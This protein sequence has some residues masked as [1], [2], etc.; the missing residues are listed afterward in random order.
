MKRLVLYILCIW[1]IGAAIE[2]NDLNIAVIW[3]SSTD[4]RLAPRGWKVGTDVTNSG[5]DTTIGACPAPEIGKAQLKI[6]LSSFERSVPFDSTLDTTGIPDVLRNDGGI[7]DGPYKGKFKKVR[8][9]DRSSMPLTLDDIK[10]DFK[11]VKPDA[12]IYI[13]AGAEWVKPGGDDG[14]LYELLRAAADN[15]IGIMTIGDASLI[16]AR[17]IDPSKERFPVMGVQKKYRFKAY[18][19]DAT[20]DN[21][22]IREFNFVTTN[23]TPEWEIPDTVVLHSDYDASKNNAN[24]A[25]YWITLG[26]DTIYYKTA[27]ETPKINETILKEEDILHAYGEW[28]INAKAVEVVDED[29]YAPEMAA[30][31]Y[32]NHDM[33]LT[34]SGS[35]SNVTPS[36][37][38]KP[39][40]EIM[41]VNGDKH[42]S[43]NEA[44]P[45][46]AS[47]GTSSGGVFRFDKDYV[48]SKS[49]IDDNT[50]TDNI[51]VIKKGDTIKASAD[52]KD[53]LY[54]NT[55]YAGGYKNL[56]IR[57]FDD[58]ATENIF[59]DV[60][61]KLKAAGIKDLKFKPWT[62]G[63][64]IKAA[65]DIWAVNEKLTL[66]DF[67]DIDS[68]GFDPDAYYRAYLGDQV[69]GTKGNPHFV[70][71]PE[72]GGTWDNGDFDKDAKDM[73]LDSLGYD[74]DGKLYH[75][76]SA[77]QNGHRR[78]VMLGFQPSYLDDLDAVLDLLEDATKWI[79]ID[80]YQLPT[81]E[82][83]PIEDGKELKPADGQKIYTDQDSIKLV[84]DFTKKGIVLHEAAFK[85]TYEI[86]YGSEV[87]NGS[88]TFEADDGSEHIEDTIID[89]TSLISIDRD[90]TAD[91]ELKISVF[92]EPVVDNAPFD[93]SNTASARLKIRKLDAKFKSGGNNESIEFEGTYNEEIISDKS[94]YGDDVSDVKI[95]F[96]KD[97]G[98]WQEEDATYKFST[99][100]PTLSIVATAKKDRY[101]NSDTLQREYEK[102]DLMLPK[103]TVDTKAADVNGTGKYFFFANTSLFMGLEKYEMTGGIAIT[104]DDY[105]L[106]FKQSSA[107]KTMPDTGLID[108]PLQYI[109]S[110]I[111]EGH[112]AFVIEDAI[113]VAE[114]QS[115]LENSN[116]MDKQS[117]EFR[118]VDLSI[119]R[120][121]GS[122][123]D[124][125][126]KVTFK[127]TDP[128]TNEE[129]SSAKI[130]YSIDGSNAT[131]SS[132]GPIN[133]SDEVEII[134]G[135]T[136]KA[137]AVRSGY[138]DGKETKS[139]AKDVYIIAD[140]ESGTFFGESLD[141][142]LTSNHQPIH[143]TIDG[144]SEL[145]IDATEGDIT[146]D[147]ALS[148]L[149]R[150]NDTVVIKAWIED[151]DNIEGVTETFSYYR[152]K[153][154][155]PKVDPASGKY[156]GSVDVTM[157]VDVDD[158]YDVDIYHAGNSGVDESKTKYSGKF[159]VEPDTTIYV[160][161]F[162][163]DWLPSN[164]V[165][166]TYTR[167][168]VSEK[169]YYFDADA[170][171]IIDS[172][173]ITLDTVFEGLSVPD[174]IKAEL[175]EGGDAIV[176]TDKSKFTF[177]GSRLTVAIDGFSTV[178]TGFSS[179]KYVTLYGER[180]NQD[181]VSI[182]DSVAPVIASARYTSGAYGS[183][184]VDRDV[185]TLLITFTEDLES[186]SDFDKKVLFNFK[187]ESRDYTADVSLFKKVSD[188]E[189]LFIVDD[190]KG[191]TYPS[192]GD[193]I[194]I[195]IGSD[196]PEITD[197]RD[198]TQ[199]V[200]DNRKVEMVVGKL[201]ISVIMNC[202]WID[203]NEN[204]FDQVGSADDM[205]TLVGGHSTFGI[206]KGGLIV[207]DP[208]IPYLESE[209]DEFGIKLKILDAVGNVVAELDEMA[210]GEH[211]KALPAE[212]VVN[213]DGDKRIVIAVAWDGNNNSNRSVHRRAYKVIAVTKWPN[214]DDEQTSIELIPVV[215][216][217]TE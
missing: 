37:A 182:S 59:E 156:S 193:S 204:G 205:V 42:A 211:I 18:S 175:P 188:K 158:K 152:R 210:V 168:L 4:S 90:N 19:S 206:S 69:A 121:S 112:K 157:S 126:I 89:I 13:N 115:K 108:L 33:I 161:A 7:A 45:D 192:R 44:I 159:T 208:R 71:P 78:M 113:T 61:P 3:N 131:E 41:W 32:P 53:L 153:L 76:I 160:K 43:L 98:A 189:Y 181:G 24:T 80:D 106:E 135:V 54:A 14:G 129:L 164:E 2:V 169:G 48:V 67:D 143:Y 23:D 17:N 198:N 215:R 163:D 141:V 21:D 72:K 107:S 12:I 36:V 134:N 166:R 101:I 22:T 145:K 70:K 130:Y 138:M 124:E 167:V 87:K 95:S 207:I 105:D 79:A 92:A 212:I 178:L 118:T 120:T 125:K 74:Q 85:V 26:T 104:N 148:S 25:S 9:Y 10:Q 202:Y 170:D 154:P 136:V 88:V 171:G 15:D 122:D 186:L 65:A 109:D 1:G 63:G 49:N 16:D 57:L 190:L 119:E 191:V 29:L 194:W 199:G 11:D 52:D 197:T 117:Y 91:T 213:K 132:K 146:L 38:N 162:A 216:E 149:I 133:S 62:K 6:L 60:F 144:G 35:G 127:A 196:I 116:P 203:Q 40:G 139:Y 172:A 86:T 83:I 187:S 103:P 93:K 68:D 50:F 173:V 96:S 183:D 34:A 151:S 142:T 179:G 123:D 39:W 110:L 174:S 155:D 97:G 27:K 20:G 31:V 77:I 28:S 195:N 30:G 209:V 165:S 46:F 47:F 177:D 94:I 102:Q 200:D 214:I 147:D 73:R 180:Y 217:Y 56:K 51:L 75:V 184:D 5:L 201:N 114:D 137:I 64:R 84:I 81:P 8:I 66:K 128:V 99:N 176:I 140:P 58:N 111:D 55:Y 185:D 150:D 82:I 100:D